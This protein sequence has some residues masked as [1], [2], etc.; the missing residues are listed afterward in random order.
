MGLAKTS[1][2]QALEAMPTFTGF[3]ILARSLLGAAGVKPGWG[4]EVAS[5]TL[6]SLP[7]VLARYS[8]ALA[9]ALAA[10]SSGTAFALEG[11]S[12][13]AAALRIGASFA[14]A[15]GW[16]G[17]INF[18]SNW[19]ADNIIG[20]LWCLWSGNYDTSKR[21][22][23]LVRMSQQIYNVDHVGSFWSAVLPLI[24]RDEEAILGIRDS[25]I[26]GSKEFGE[27]VEQNIVSIVARSART[28]VD[29]AWTVDWDGVESGVKAFYQSEE[30]AENIRKGYE[31]IDK[32]TAPFLEFTVA[33]LLKVVDAEGNI[34]DR[35]KF[36]KYF[37]VYANQQLGEKIP[38]LE[39]KALELG[40]AEE[41][42]G[43][44]VPRLPE[45]PDENQ[46]KFLNGE[47]L[48]LS[49]EIAFLSGLKAALL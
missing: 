8:P 35:E 24:P 28:D 30:N 33:P 25:L 15:L 20:N 32:G 14:N 36:K 21:L 42:D 41:V 12:A 37:R 11:L 43:E 31:L 9:E 4:S 13:G 40:M 47:G 6:A 17:L 44:V 39:R 48:T 46:L 38:R 16:L 23:N 19:M 22:W 2:A 29:G 7:F 34:P 45:M 27:S 49:Q 26:A 5:L 18:G 3:Q 10:A 1:P